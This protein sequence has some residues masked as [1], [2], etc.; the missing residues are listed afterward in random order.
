M[1]E[2]TEAKDAIGSE[3][4]PQ[5]DL[6]SHVFRFLVHLVWKLH[7]IVKRNWFCDLVDSYLRYF[8]T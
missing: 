2:A 3:L 4:A 6:R 1:L 7:L 8:Q 5:L